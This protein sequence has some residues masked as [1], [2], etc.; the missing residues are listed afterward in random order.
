MSLTKIIEEIREM[1]RAY[2]EY[3]EKSLGASI[4]CA[5]TSV[6]SLMLLINKNP[7]VNELLPLI[8][9]YFTIL[10]ASDYLA[11]DRISR[12]IRQ[13]YPLYFENPENA[14]SQL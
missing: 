6:L 10:N 3:S 13:N 7:F 14:N 5:G 4:F 8:G 9:T 12:R 11:G 1:E 2:R